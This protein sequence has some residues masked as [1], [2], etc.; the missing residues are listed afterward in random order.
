MYKLARRQN[1]REDIDRRK[2]KENSRIGRIIR[3]A[4]AIAQLFH[5]LRRGV[6]NVHRY[7]NCFVLLGCFLCLPHVTKVNEK[8]K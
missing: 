6:A 4:L 2:A 1:N 5:Q 3:I 7:T 8:E